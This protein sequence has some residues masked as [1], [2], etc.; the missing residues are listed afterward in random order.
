MESVNLRNKYKI[1]PHYYDKYEVHQGLRKRDGTGVLVGLT[2]IGDVHGYILDEGNKVPV[3]GR[4]TYRGINVL[5]LI[6]ACLSEDRFGFEETAYLLLFGDLPTTAQLAEFTNTLRERQYLPNDF[7]EDVILSAPSNNIMNKLAQCVLACYAY[8]SE[9]DSTELEVVVNQCIDLIAR[10]PVMVAYAYQAKQRYYEGK[11]LFIR[12]PDPSLS[13]AE[14]FLQMFRQTGEYSKLEATILDLALIL[15][16]EHGG[17]NNS[18]FAVHVVSST[19]T[20][21]YSAISAA[22]G[23]LKGPRHGGA[24][25]AVLD[26]MSEIKANV[27]NWASTDEVWNYLGK[28]VKK[29]AGDGS[30]LIYGIGHAVY[31]E[32]DPRSEALKTYAVSLAKEKGRQDEM[33]LYLLIEKLAPKVFAEVKGSDKV[34]AANVDFFSGFVYQML[35]IPDELCTPIFAMSRIVGWCAHRIDELVN[36]GRIIRPAYRNADKRRKY[37][38]IKNR[39]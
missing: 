1:E 3:P 5:D 17:G 28:I 4:L 27:K 2:R 8:D 22:V 19:G 15:H 35:D 7:A 30:G 32:S 14:N 24:N 10:F 38:S 9:P 13:V 12:M 39:N 16:A 20:D 26:M 25:I 29:E 34:V 6:K 21:T 23:S 36:G 18:T 11:N 37:I 33:E 31:T